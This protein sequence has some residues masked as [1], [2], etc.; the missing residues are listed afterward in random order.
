M[1]EKQ[2]SLVILGSEHSG[3]TCFLGGLGIC[4]EADR[5]GNIMLSAEGDSLAY[6][7]EITQILRAQEWP[8]A[9]ARGYH[10]QFKAT[11]TYQSKM[12]NLRCIDFAGETFRALSRGE[13]LPDFVEEVLSNA[14][15]I[16]L[17]LD[18]RVDTERTELSE[19]D[20]EDR[21][22]YFER[23]A[24]LVEMA[25]RLTIATAGRRN[26]AHLAVVITKAD[27]LDDPLMTSNQAKHYLRTKQPD[28][29]KRLETLQPGIQV[30]P[31][32]AVGATDVDDSGR[33]IPARILNPTGYEEILS[34]IHRDIKKRRRAPFVKAITGVAI[35]AAIVAAFGFF[36]LKQTEVQLVQRHEDRIA[37]GLSSEEVPTAAKEVS[38]LPTSYYAMMI[39]DQL[40]KFERA[41]ADQT[42]NRQAV[43]RWRDQLDMYSR[44]RD[45]QGYRTGEIANAL[46]QANLWLHDFDWNR[47]EQ[48]PNGPQHPDWRDLTK[49]FRAAWPNSPRIDEIDAREGQAQQERMQSV[50]RNIEEAPLDTIAQL[51]SRMDNILRF[52]EEFGTYIDNHVAKDIESAHAIARRFES[53][54]TN[55]QPFTFNLVRLGRLTEPGYIDLEVHVGS[56]TLSVPQS[57][58]VLEHS[59]E[60]NKELELPWK[61]NE[62]LTFRMH[63]Q[64][65]RATTFS[66]FVTFRSTKRPLAQHTFQ[67][68]PLSII[69][70]GKT[71]AEND[72]KLTLASTPEEGDAQYLEG[73]LATLE[74][75]IKDFPWGDWEKLHDW[76][77][78]GTMWKQ[79]QE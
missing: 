76:V 31:V 45:K 38:Q 34:W 41:L 19:A 8:S 69:A 67:G 6:L 47:L 43:Q 48:L 36:W 30:F 56:Q 65:G 23:L 73:N 70:M 72:G 11:V 16:L 12:L 28:F 3:K 26:K 60:G 4:S 15:Y 13:E 24:S 71:L 44:A 29:L 39:D 14:R 61:F 25:Q 77:Y 10:R 1:S 9:T 74:L 46:A 78:P 79:F 35:V 42:T 52:H 49:T 59:F 33:A 5:A 37:R 27:S 66:R 51:R 50:A 20:V 75:S 63:V 21:Q 55:N 18:P 68:S 53:K 64:W 2:H 54:L 22:R 62:S 32:S 40:K 7:H 58:W 17:A 57:S